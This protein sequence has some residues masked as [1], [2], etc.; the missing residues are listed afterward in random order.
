MV[1]Y[2]QEH[3]LLLCNLTMFL[4]SSE[5]CITSYHSKACTMPDMSNSTPNSYRLNIFLP[6][7]D[8]I[9]CAISGHNLV[10]DSRSV[11]K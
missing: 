7:L 1:A 4:T 10:R 6:F 5:F 2:I 8:F 11:V 3:V 9:F